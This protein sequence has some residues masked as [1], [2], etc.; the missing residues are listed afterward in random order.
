MTQTLPPPTQPPAGQPEGHVLLRNISW[1]TYRTLLDEIGDSPTRLTYDRG[2]L[3]IEVPSR[4]HEQLKRF[5][6]ELAE[7]YMKRTGIEY[8]PSGSTTWQREAELRGLEAD[9][10]YHVQHAALVRGRD[11]LDLAVDPPPDL[12]IE[13]DVTSSSLDKLPLHGA[14]GVPEVWRV[15]GTGECQIYSREPDGTYRDVGA[16][17]CVPGM[18]AAVL[19]RYMSLRQQVGHS[20]AV[21]RFEADVFGG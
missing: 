8:E 10:C 6:G 3:E 4:H 15:R 18:T 2:L 7:T 16:S 9:E 14:L 11:Q 20:Q 1:R 13:V 17:I 21:R 12:A 19:A 5:V